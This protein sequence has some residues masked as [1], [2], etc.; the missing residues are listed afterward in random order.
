MGSTGWRI[1]AVACGVQLLVAL[2]AGCGET[3]TS[4]PTR[5]GG[6]ADPASAAQVADGVVLYAKHCASCHGVD[7]SGQPNWRTALP[8]GGYPAPPHDG[9]GHTW[10]HGDQQLLDAT[11][12]GGVASA[13]P[14]TKSHMPAFENA[15]TDDEIWAVLAFIK[16][17]WPSELVAR[18]KLVTRMSSR[19]RAHAHHPAP[20][21]APPLTTPPVTAPAGDHRARL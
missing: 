6:L 19:A 12:Y 14:G 7:L 10:R 4:I 21:T 15:L 2:A 13:G 18:Q 9:T 5:S 20:L 16:S 3:R 1:G 11:K 8:G 17:R